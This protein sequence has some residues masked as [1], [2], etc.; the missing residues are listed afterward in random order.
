MYYFNKMRAELK[1][2]INFYDPKEKKFYKIGDIIEIEVDKENTPI[3]K[4]W[5]G[6]L[7]FNHINKALELNIIKPKYKK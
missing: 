6:Q 7:K 4:F 3:D 1:F 2:L 5:R